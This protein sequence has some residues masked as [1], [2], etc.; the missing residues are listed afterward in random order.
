MS[1]I[2]RERALVHVEANELAGELRGPLGVLKYGSASLTPNAE[3]DS[4]F[5]CVHS[6]FLTCLSEKLACL[7]EGEHGPQVLPRPCVCGLDAQGVLEGAS[8]AGVLTYSE[9]QD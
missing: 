8:S 2:S 4:P 7:E 9:R 1:G 5:K 3:Q 6:R